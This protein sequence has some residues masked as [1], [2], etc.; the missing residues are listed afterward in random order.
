MTD[1][2]NAP[3]GKPVNYKD[4]YDVSLLFPISR[5]HQRA[6][7]NLNQALPF[8]GYDLWNAYE[9]SWLDTKGKPEV[10]IGQFIVPCDSPHLFES[11]SLKLYLN[12][13]NGTKFGGLVNVE[14][15][16]ARDLS[17]IAGAP[18]TV[19]IKRLS[20]VAD[21]Y[22]SNLMHF[23]GECLDH[24]NVVCN[25]YTV[26]PEYLKTTGEENVTE[27]LY[28]NLLKSNCLKTGQPDWGSVQISYTGKP[29]DKQGLLQY[30][31]SFRAHQGFHE[32]CVEQM[33]VDIMK[34]CSPDTL[35]VEAR[36][37]RRGGLD[38]NPLRT[39]AEVVPEMEMGRLWRH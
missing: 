19:N 39:N 16:I 35:T 23:K 24:L 32:D 15:T 31:V 36:Y 18:V 13:L 22:N 21:S 4:Q 34:Q 7:L 27:I 20:E 29:I 3:L 25:T 17:A 1:L 6:S 14:N 12:S 11:K 8:K 5:S 33:F 37:T 26:H 2:Q 28:S 38:I 30:I 10:A 9:L